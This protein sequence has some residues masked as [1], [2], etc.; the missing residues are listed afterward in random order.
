M[1]HLLSWLINALRYRANAQ[2]GQRLIERVLVFKIDLL[3]DFVLAVPALMQLQ[4]AFPKA[5]FTYVVSP[6]SVEMAR[7]LGDVAVIP[8]ESSFFYPYRARV[9][10]S[11]MWTLARTLA[12]ESPD[13]IVDFRSDP[14]SLMVALLARAGHRIEIGA[15]RIGPTLRK[16]LG[17]PT[18]PALHE[19]EVY[20]VAVRRWMLTSN[21]ADGNSLPASLGPALL[22]KVRTGLSISGSALD[23]SDYAVLHIG[24]SARFKRWPTARFIAL[25]TR[26]RARTG[27]RCVLVGSGSERQL[28]ENAS[29]DLFDGV[30]LVDLVGQTDLLALF[31]VVAGAR[32]VVANDSAV[33]HIA[34][35]T[36][37][38]VITIYGGPSDPSAFAP[39]GQGTCR[40]IRPA[41][42]CRTAEQDHC[43]RGELRW[44][45]GQ[46]GIDEVE[47]LVDEVLSSPAPGECR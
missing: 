27:L 37:R 34:A 9:S 16:W 4:R 26:L 12:T 19:S 33:G 45:L 21:A 11:R 38:R 43:A 14:V 46:V 30:D 42:A 24:G 31:A 5:Q 29:L 10:L 36:G 28:L 13:L 40:V 25:A 47:V 35:A 22:F 3:G 2:T 32:L 6:Q 7:L 17:L 44:C 20:D 41:C 23:S 1:V 8:Y 18:A 39:R 15:Q